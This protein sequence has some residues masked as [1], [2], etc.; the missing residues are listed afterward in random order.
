MNDKLVTLI[1][2]DG[3]GMPK[4]DKLDISG[5]LPENTPYLQ[6]LATKYPCGVLEASGEAVGLSKNQYGTSEVGHATIGSGRVNFQPM[7]KINKDI[8]NG[9][10]FNNKAFLH[11]IEN[12][13]KKN[14]ALHLMGIVS[15]GGVHSHIDHLI[16][17]LKLA[18]KQGLEK[19]YVHFISD[20]RDTPPKS[21]FVYYD[22]VEKAIK[23]F[24]VGEIVDVCGR[25][26]ALDRDNNWDRVQ[27]FYDAVVNGKAKTAT[28]LKKAVKQ[29]YNYGETDEFLKPIIKVDKNGKYAGKI[30]EYDSVIIFNYRADR[31]RQLAKV[32]VDGNGIEWARKLHLTL[33][34]MT[35]FD[36]KLNDVVI[37]YS[38]EKPTNILSEVLSKKGY[39]QYKI[40]ET[41]KFAHLTFFFNSGR[42]TP[43]KNEKQVL[44]ASEKLK[45]YDVK[46]EMSAEKIAKSAVEAIKSGEFQTI[47][48]NFANG[49]MVGHSGNLDAS[50]IAVGVVDEC[51]K[52]V[53]EATKK[54]GGVTII[55]A[56]HGNC[57]L[58]RY[59]NGEPHKSH[60]MAL[61]PVIIVK[62]GLRPQ[63]K[64]IRGTLA[65][66][67]PTILNF[68]GEKI[69]KEMTGKTLI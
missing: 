35:N 60:T 17:L 50:R 6:A 40:A 25:F 32:F 44:I 64:E 29:A 59:P 66:I 24:G 26:Y 38:D 27:I 28:D 16:A 4:A 18:K 45:T 54:C 23:E 7:V 30:A 15:D 52:K 68:L 51:V 37:A 31:G 21:M 67:A 63:P 36:E 12:A 33:V 61:V 14:K 9:S 57:D 53:T 3:V 46:P 8:E 42:Q 10:F 2:M 56:D 19:V 41:E 34:T 22:A 1:I 49:D 62:E 69:P 58:M 13:K 47:F 65:D 55:T 48:I 5:V 43:F 20:G 11:A 39:K